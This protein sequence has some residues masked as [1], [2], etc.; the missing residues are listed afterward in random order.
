MPTPEPNYGDCST[1]QSLIDIGT[2]YRAVPIPKQT[3]QRQVGGLRLGGM[4]NASADDRQPLISIVTVVYNG[5]STIEQTLISVLR[6]TYSHVEYIIVDGASSDGTIDIIRR[7]DPALSLWISEPDQGIGDAMNKGIKLASGD[8]VLMLHSDDYL[9]AN[10][11]L[12]NVA[13][14]LR[15]G[16]DIVSGRLMLDHGDGLQ[17]RQPRPWNWR[18]NFKTSLWHQATFCHRGLFERIGLFNT[19]LQIA[20]DYDFFLRAYRAGVSAKLI[21]QV[22]SVMRH[23][24]ISASTD[25]Q[26]LAI[27]FGE[28]RSIHA[29]HVDSALLKLIYHLYWLAYPRYRGVSL[30][31]RSP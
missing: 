4:V 29:Q 1:R 10:D 7:Y 6:Q 13:P 2:C 28:E 17:Q 11:C 26:T 19:G 30:P 9:H 22:I 5:V 8:Y 27:R 16:H 31:P 23:S 3:R 15:Q 24:G 25:P 20:M 14:Y 21:E 12:E 18:L